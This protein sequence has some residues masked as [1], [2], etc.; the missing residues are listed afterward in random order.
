MADES[1][2]PPPEA[3]EAPSPETP[4]EAAAPIPQAHAEANT[5]PLYDIS[6]KEPVLGSIDHNEVT[7]AVAS[8]RYTFPRGAP[9]PVIN[10]DGE[11]GT[12]DPTEA[13]EAFQNGYKYATPKD[14]EMHKYAQEPLTAAAEGVAKGVL[15]PLATWVELMF[16]V[17][18][19][20][21][22]GREEANPWAHGLGEAAGFVGSL[23]TGVGQAAL[24][25]QA[26]KG[27]AK[28]IEGVGLLSD[29]ARGATRIGAEMALLQS[30]DEVSKMI[31]EDPNQ[32]VGTAIT[33]I[34]LAGALGGLM[35]GAGSGIVSPLWKSVME[36]KVG[37]GL[38][39]LQ[40][41]FKWAKETGDIHEAVTKELGDQYSGIKSVSDDVYGPSGLKAQEIQKLVPEL[42]PKMM[43]QANLVSEDLTKQVNK[44]IAKSNS[45]PERLSSKLQDDLNAYRE[46]VSNPEAS[47]HDMFNATQD[48]KQKLQGYAKFDKFV[49][50]V[51][52]AYDFVR[53]SKS[54]AAKLRESLEDNKVWGPAAERQQAINKAFTQFKPALEDFESK[55][56]TEMADPE[57]GYKRVID[58]AKVQ[59]LLNQSGKPTGELK[60]QMLENYLKASEKYKDVLA[61]THA[62]LGL[63]MPVGPSSL[64]ATQG[65]L[66]KLTPGA[67]LADWFIK[68]GMVETAA[69]SAG[70]GIGAVL[71]HTT[72]IPGAGLIGSLVGTQAIAPALKSILPALLKPLMEKEINPTAFKAAMEYASSV[73]KGQELISK[74][75]Q[76]VFKLERPV[77]P[78]NAMPSEKDRTKLDKLLKVAQKDPS[79][80]LDGPGSAH[81]HYLPAHATTL[82]ATASSAVQQ[83]NAQRP[84][85]DRASPLDS[86][87]IIDKAHQAAYNRTLDI[88][89]QPLVVLHHMKQGTLLPSDVAT[90]QRLYPELYQKLSKDLTTQMIEH[91]SKGDG[92]NSVP[93]KTRMGISMFLAQPMDSTM[94]PQSIMAAQPLPEQAPQGQ[95]PQGG[96]PNKHSSNA[97]NKTASSYMTKT[98]SREQDR[99]KNNNS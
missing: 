72:G 22:A 81:G 18:P 35:G 51:D 23:A 24:V 28:G 56:T 26:G 32:S 17:D 58:P 30:G 16:G 76:N 37:Q 97:L 9:V 31:T 63:D 25:E 61:K 78:E 19:K 2:V 27:L 11:H 5:T 80:L 60:K 98:Q 44:M 20:A 69:N 87:P 96:A 12:L 3:A 50:P 53:D 71:G 4:I 6:G 92:N 13:P 46:V 38:A 47:S 39:D 45:Y 90:V 34:G 73:V 1:F 10:P 66:G 88:A 94:K 99:Q 93:Y 21:I 43:D 65:A 77:L 15:G 41:R 62:N 55:F 52:D 64:H 74:A 84:S 57:G 91:M 33:N 7:D 29:A 89:Q 8:G 85:T 36:G 75:T 42:S 54:M 14:L 49:K 40:G 59:T 95:Q 70:A 86:K 68:K 67:A 79:A 82:A 83:L 48:L